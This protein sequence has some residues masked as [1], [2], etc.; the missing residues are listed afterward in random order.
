M[1]KE[2]HAGKRADFPIYTPQ[3]LSTIHAYTE[4]DGRHYMLVKVGIADTVFAIA[5][6]EEQMA[7]LQKSLAEMMLRVQSK[8]LTG[9]Q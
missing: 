3:K 6:H 9:V 2:Y 4:A 7:F 1:D 8:A 5:L